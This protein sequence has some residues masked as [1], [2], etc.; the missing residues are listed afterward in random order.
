MARDRARRHRAFGPSLRRRPL[1]VGPRGF[2][3]RR[4]TRAHKL[5]NEL[6]EPALRDLLLK[7]LEPVDFRSLGVREFG[8]IYEGLLESEL[9]VAE[10]DLALDAKGSYI[11][12]TKKTVVVVQKDDVYLHDKSGAS[13][14]SGSYFTNSFAVEHLLDKALV[15]ALQ[16]HLLDCAP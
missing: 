9:S 1:L 12:A 8:T 13:K 6:F 7:D 11:P 3:R 16:D 14:S 2:A 4:R 15:P 10:Q 5:P